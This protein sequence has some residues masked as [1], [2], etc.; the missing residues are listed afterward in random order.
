MGQGASAARLVVVNRYYA[1]VGWATE[2]G[3]A[4]C[5]RGSGYR[6]SGQPTGK[7]VECWAPRS[8]LLS[9]GA[10][11]QVHARLGHPR[12]LSQ[13]ATTD[14]ITVCSSAPCPAAAGHSPPFHP[15]DAVGEPQPPPLP[16]VCVF[17]SPAAR[18]ERGAATTARAATCHTGPGPEGARAACSAAW[19][20]PRGDDVSVQRDYIESFRGG[21]ACSGSARALRGGRSGSSTRASTAPAE[22]RPGGPTALELGAAPRQDRFGT[23]TALLRLRTSSRVLCPALAHSNSALSFP[24]H[25]PT[26]PPSPLTQQTNPTLPPPAPA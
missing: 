17:T 21:D 20:G 8:H 1:S 23:R 22:G 5:E 18:R 16:L 3:R 13:Q 24:S 25:P 6:C 12:F 9:S 4:T 10:Q 14:F 7:G 11:R 15:S 2:P 19:A 26:H